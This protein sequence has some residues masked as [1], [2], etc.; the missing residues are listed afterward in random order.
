MYVADEVRDADPLADRSSDEPRETS[1]SRL[2][3]LQ[4]EVA[5]L[6]RELQTSPPPSG[7]T[8]IPRGNQRKSILPARQPVDIVSELSSLR[9]RLNTASD[10]AQ[11]SSDDTEGFSTRLRQ[12]EDVGL[13]EKGATL[14]PPATGQRGQVG[15][16]DKRLAVLERA[17]GIAD[18]ELDSVSTLDM[19]F[20]DYDL[21]NQLSLSDTL[22]RLDH[23][24]NV[25]TQPRHLDSIAR[26]VKVLLADLDRA[27]A[28]RRPGGPS[29]PAPGGSVTLS[30]TDLERLNSLFALLP[31]LDPLLPVIPPLLTRL[32]SLSTLHAES[33][34]IAEDLRGLQASDRTIGGE[35]RELQAIVSGVQ[36]G[37][38]DATAS[39]SKNWESLQ[40][41]LKALDDKLAQLQV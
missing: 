5:Q 41:R 40:S 25:L 34:S 18:V 3:R 37:M 1:L 4:S 24:M 27:A 6:E 21:Q 31:R 23:F 9:E 19:A 38:S 26:R 22:A 12:L 35:E 14:P 28:S 20:S 30:P 39:I 33:I 36:Q 15:E 32:R 2:R 13:G 10:R 17:V 29:S 7:T 16:V 11:G 8:N